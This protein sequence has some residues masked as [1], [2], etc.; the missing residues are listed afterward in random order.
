MFLPSFMFL[1][2]LLIKLLTVLSSIDE[3]EKAGCFT[4]TVLLMSCDCLCSAA[5]PHGADC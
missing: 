5:L 2:L 1:V 4:L 3:E